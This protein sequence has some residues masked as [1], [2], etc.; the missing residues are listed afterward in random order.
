MNNGFIL[1]RLVITGIDCKPA[2]LTFDKGTNV[3]VGPSNTGKT[4][5]YQCIEYLLGREKIPKPI[6][7]SEAYDKAFLEIETIN[8]D[9]CTLSRG[10]SGG[11]V[12]LFD[13]SYSEIT[14]KTD[15]ETLLVGSKETKKYRPLSKYLLTLCG[16]E[17]RRV[18][19]N[20]RGQT[21]NVTFT[22]LRRLCAI[23][24]VKILKE[25]SPILGGQ[26][27]DETKEKNIFRLLLTGRDDSNIIETPKPMVVAR[28]TG[29]LELLESLIKEHENELGELGVDTSDIG[30]RLGKLND[31]INNTNKELNQYY[32]VSED[33]E[34]TLSSYWE[35]WRIN[36]SRLITVD[37]LLVRFELLSKH[38]DSDIERLDAITETSE[39]FSDYSIGK[40]PVCGSQLDGK[41][42]EL[43]NKESVE[44]VKAATSAE[45]DKI[46]ILKADLED[47][48]KGLVE[49]KKI[50]KYE[51]ETARK[52]HQ[53]LDKKRGELHTEKIKNLVNT[54]E[55]LRSTKYKV[56]RARDIERKL[57]MHREERDSIENEIE[58]AISEAPYESLTTAMTTGMCN[59]IAILLRK[60]KY[61]NM[62]NITFS[63]STSD[64]VINGQDRNLSGKGYRALSYT[65]FIIGL[66]NFCAKNNKP[67]A[68]FVLI[69]SP[70]VTLRSKNVNANEV[71]S[72][73]V[74]DSFYKS[75]AYNQNS[76]QII[77]LENDPPPQEITSRINYEV[78][79]QDKNNGRYGFIPSR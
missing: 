77:I 3:I 1:K 62:G 37:E 63:E 56:E 35:S 74:K 38:Y 68:G 72:D 55:K 48:V 70:L 34:S 49:E 5:V 33:I 45:A 17:N 16:L 50:L 69:D 31:S 27:Q 51:I 47:T 13:C 21:D 71:I 28:K 41:E 19:K 15:H 57:I 46:K 75:I 42:H 79:T 73:E 29:R 66:M 78:F 52:K 23:D 40:C 54:V 20:A 25:S 67:H 2:E 7:E 44:S 32:S 11:E 64:I 53:E 18:R 9:L 4:Y 30:E 22:F 60:W 39:L 76:G 36:E 14:D 10:L 26:R 61:P 24:E 65:G 59:E 43:C 6:P 8:G 12:Y 58:P